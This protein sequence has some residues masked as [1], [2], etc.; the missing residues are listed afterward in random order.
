MSWIEASHIERNSWRL[1]LLWNV[2]GWMLRWSLIS[3]VKNQVWPE[4][5]GLIESVERERD[6]GWETEKKVQRAFTPLHSFFLF[7]HSRLVQRDLQTPYLTRPHRQ[8][9]RYILRA[10]YVWCVSVY[11]KGWGERRKWVRGVRGRRWD[12]PSSFLVSR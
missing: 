12:L 5:G 9:E 1:F 6:E 4:S 10:G 2:T 11:P 7:L 8:A 3:L